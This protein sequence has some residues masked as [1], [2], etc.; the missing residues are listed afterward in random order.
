VIIHGTADAVADQILSFAAEIG[1]TDL[2]AAPL[3][4]RTFRLLTD[5]VLPRIAG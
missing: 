2:M 4:G 5:K 1:M 3:S